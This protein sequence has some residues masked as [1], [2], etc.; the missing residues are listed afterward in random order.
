MNRL[1]EKK[2]FLEE[3]EEKLSGYTETEQKDTDFL[4]HSLIRYILEHPNSEHLKTKSKLELYAGK[5]ALKKKDPTFNKTDK[6]LKPWLK[7][8]HPEFVPTE[9]KTVEKL[10]WAG[11]KEM[12]KPK[13]D[14]NGWRV[15]DKDDNEVEGVNFVEHEPELEIII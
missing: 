8:H 13:A 2:T 14:D 3:H 12:L 6:E 11:F 1:E 15:F 5:I 9:T 10:D 7:K 4:I